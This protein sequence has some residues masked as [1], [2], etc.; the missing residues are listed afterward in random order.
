MTM[1][2]ELRDRDIERFDKIAT[3]RKQ[4]ERAREMGKQTVVHPI[5]ITVIVEILGLLIDLVAGGPPPPPVPRPEPHPTSTV[6][7]QALASRTRT[8]KYRLGARVRTS[9]GLEG[10]VDAIFADL[11]AVF[12]KGA[13]SFDRG[14]IQNAEAL[15][16]AMQG[17]R[18]KTPKDGVWYSVV[19]FDERYVMTLAGEDDLQQVSDL[20]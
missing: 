15:W 4:F 18:P 16:A 5:A 11:E 9:A 13:V 12:D 10:A 3:L 17:S 1:A 14:N 6:R 8:P 7:A 20:P 2:G 19:L